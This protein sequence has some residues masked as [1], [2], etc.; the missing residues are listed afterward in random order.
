MS[1]DIKSALEIARGKIEQLG[2]ATEEERLRWK[3]SPQ[4]E[5]MAA[6]YLKEDLNLIAELGKHPDKVRKY[7]ARGMA[8][9][10]IR[11]I[12]L[13]RNDVIKKTNK[14]AMDGLKLVKSDKAK[15]ENVFSQIRRLFEHY[16][17]QGEQQRKQA[18]QALK[19]DLEAKMQ[20]ALQQQMGV[21]GGGT[22]RID[23]ERQPQF[24]QEWRRLQVQLDAQY[25][26]LLNE[27]K[28]ELLSIP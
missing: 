12:S 19:N 10:L 8:E 3:Y 16:V 24:Q 7:V 6:R 5:Q 27:Y 17:T 15:V 23:V 2:E 1:D 11:N 22:P 25:L 18:Y 21:M 26:T 4:G 14:K 13:P 20:Q 28:E 9:V